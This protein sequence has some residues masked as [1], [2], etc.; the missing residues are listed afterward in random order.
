MPAHI[1]NPSVGAD[2]SHRR[3]VALELAPPLRHLHRGADVFRARH[4]RDLWRG[5][6]IVSGGGLGGSAPA[7][8]GRVSL[9]AAQSCPF[10]RNI[11]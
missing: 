2:H 3:E 8:F 6:F 7:P 10:G 11:A 5:G 4:P 9:L 1:N